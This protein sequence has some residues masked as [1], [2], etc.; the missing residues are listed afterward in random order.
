M[1]EHIMLKGWGWRP[2]LWSLTEGFVVRPE[3]TGFL[4]GSRGFGGAWGRR[5]SKIGPSLAG[6]ASEA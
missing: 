2:S 4:E 5:C 1:P 6:H 3:E